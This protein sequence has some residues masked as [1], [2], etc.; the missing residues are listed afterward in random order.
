MRA[1]PKKILDSRGFFLGRWSTVYSICAI[2]ALAPFT[3]LFSEG[4]PSL[5]T[6]ADQRNY[7][8]EV[9]EQIPDALS[10]T[11]ALFGQ[12]GPLRIL[13]GL[14][15]MQTTDAYKKLEAE[16]GPLIKL[17]LKPLINQREVT[18]LEKGWNEMISRWKDSPQDL[19][20]H[21]KELVEKLKKGGS[22]GLLTGLVRSLPSERQKEVFKLSREEKLNVLKAELPE[23]LSHTAFRTGESSEGK[24]GKE[25][26]LT[27]YNERK[28]LEENLLSA[29]ALESFLKAFPEFQKRRNFTEIKFE[30]AKAGNLREW[31]ETY[32]NLAKETLSAKHP[33]FDQSTKFTSQLFKEEVVSIPSA[34]ASPLILKEV[35]P[36]LAVFR[37]CL[38]GDCST[39]GSVGYPLSPKERVFFI[40]NS[41]GATKGYVGTAQVK[42][43][44]GDKTALYVHTINGKRLNERDIGPILDAL[45]SAKKDLK[46]DEIGLPDSGNIQAN[47][48]Y[49]ELRTALKNFLKGTE[50][51]FGVYEDNALRKTYIDHTSSHDYDKAKNTIPVNIYRPQDL[52]KQGIELTKKTHEL[53][54]K[55]GALPLA[56]LFKVAFDPSL[57]AEGRS[58][59][60]AG[61]MTPEQIQLFNSRL[62]NSEKRSVKE[63]EA[64]VEDLLESFGISKEELR[65]MMEG[66]ELPFLQGRL[67]APDYASEENRSKSIR[68]L[69][70]AAFHDTVP[71][72]KFNQ[73]ADD[74][75]LDRRFLEGVARNMTGDTPRLTEIANHLF[76]N[77]ERKA[78]LQSYSS[79]PSKQ[80]QSAVL[81]LGLIA[82]GSHRLNTISSD[83]PDLL[84][85]FPAELTKF[86]KDYGKKFYKGESYRAFLSKI[87]THES[88]ATRAAAKELIAPVMIGD[89]AMQV[90]FI[91]ALMAEIPEVQ[92]IYL[93][94][95]L[96]KLYLPY[97][98]HP[99]H[100]K[101]HDTFKSIYDAILLDNG[102][103]NRVIAQQ[104]IAFPMKSHIVMPFLQRK[105][106]EIRRIVLEEMF[107]LVR[108][109]PASF[110]TYVPDL[111]KFSFHDDLEIRNQVK[112][113]IKEAHAAD[114]QRYSG[115][116][117]P[118]LR[119]LGLAEEL[120]SEDTKETLQK[121]REKRASLQKTDYTALTPLFLKLIGS[122][123]SELSLA[124]YS[125]LENL[126][127]NLFP[128][129]YSQGIV[130]NWLRGGRE[131]LDKHI[132]KLVQTGG[133]AYEHLVPLLKN[134]SEADQ[135]RFLSLITPV[136]TDKYLL[137]DIA[138]KLT[139]S[140]NE[141]NRLGALKWLSKIKIQNDPLILRAVNMLNDPSDAVRAE[142]MRIFGTLN[143]GEVTPEVLSVAIDKAQ[144][145]D[146]SLILYTRRNLFLNNADLIKK[147]HQLLKSPDRQVQSRAQL[148]VLSSREKT[149]E[150][151]HDLGPIDFTDK[152]TLPYLLPLV[153]NLGIFHEADVSNAVERLGD[154]D[155]NIRNLVGAYLSGMPAL[156]P[157]IL[158]KLSRIPNKLSA[159][160]ILVLVSKIQNTA[161]ALGPE[162]KA[163]LFSVLYRSEL[164]VAAVAA[165]ALIEKS[166][167]T[168][169]QAESIFKRARGI[170]SDTKVDRASLLTALFRKV[171]LTPRLTELM[172]EWLATDVRSS[173]DLNSLSVLMN[174]EGL[175]P[176]IQNEIV[177]I[178]PVKD[179]VLKKYVLLV[180][181]K[182]KELDPKAKERLEKYFKNREEAFLVLNL[183]NDE[184]A[185]NKATFLLESPLLDI[186][187]ANRA[188]RSEVEGKGFGVIGTELT[189]RW[190][191]YSPP[192]PTPEE[193]AKTIALA[194]AQVA[195][196]KC[197]EPLSDVGSFEPQE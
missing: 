109:N 131:I 159:A 3:P 6:P 62:L 26:L 125:H 51:P 94:E 136:A 78:K 172:R 124:V 63:Y 116:R 115:Q 54:Y 38:G 53:P 137:Q 168:E 153:K 27:L 190:G 47:V 147:V 23:D 121:F 142:A 103:S 40:Y 81:V 68:L 44:A 76:S 140:E 154:A 13:S 122:S 160:V 1:L 135:M 70:R 195:M 7:M 165:R 184:V 66:L 181:A 145:K 50:R 5:A 196:K 107:K 8:I 83:F 36:W 158:R 110:D 88:A 106:P 28:N 87:I 35:P 84:E 4:I 180:L 102:S 186:F 132:I 167:L 31:R 86:L 95:A 187:K 174:M 90:K 32:K 16:R 170:P 144:G 19:S 155:A 73:I 149:P 56:K 17:E 59:L 60:L 29:L 175:P 69:L 108:S 34:I 111:I 9:Q 48:N 49:D 61:I 192:K 138:L 24:T 100:R 74:L 105:D 10:L 55:Q 89:Q 45:S 141:K 71:D 146:L 188:V 104:F 20:A 57:T 173:R 183:L 77:N 117:N 164:S 191:G 197:S 14:I 79:D 46:V 139:H 177:N 65:P 151:L 11:S 21:R 143:T 193:I 112:A 58:T 113:K 15:A 126:P 12:T 178:V 194:R 150:M 91:E 152:E 30:E 182:Q 163:F 98:G 42:L 161:G 185:V 127:I 114:I 162:A 37:G 134:A 93:A 52:S 128:I 18:L 2:L 119:V 176:E 75:L 118:S 43:G 96:Y 80:V 99:T 157:A 67:Q 123:D 97:K 130:E 72:L 166:D 33:L 189:R 41:E 82:D 85:D 156:S 39:S 25:E 133:K 64:G 148:I 120:F 171:K 92:K 129:N 179:E 169:A 101:Y 22:E